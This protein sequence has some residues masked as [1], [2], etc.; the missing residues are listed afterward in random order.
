MRKVWRIWMWRIWSTSTACSASFQR[1]FF[2]AP[3]WTN[4]SGQRAPWGRVGQPSPDSWSVG[5]LQK[6]PWLC[7]GETL[8]WH[9][10][11]T[12]H[13][14]APQPCPELGRSQQVLP[15]GD[16]VLVFATWLFPPSVVSWLFGNDKSISPFLTVQFLPLQGRAASLR[17]RLGEPSL[18]HT[19]PKAEHLNPQKLVRVTEL[20]SPK[21]TS[22]SKTIPQH[23]LHSC[24]SH[25]ICS[26]GGKSHTGTN[27][28]RPTHQHHQA[29]SST[30]QEKM[31]VAETAL[32][33]TART[34]VGV[35]CWQG[36]SPPHSC[37]RQG[38]K[39]SVPWVGTGC[40]QPSARTWV[41]R[42][43]Q[44]G[45]VTLMHSVLLCGHRPLSVNKIGDDFLY[46]VGF[47]DATISIWED[48]KTQECKFIDT[49][50]RKAE[51]LSSLKLSASLAVQCWYKTTE[52]T[53]LA[54]PFPMSS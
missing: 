28:P 9:I 21:S 24:S 34:Q 20:A 35:F 45:P 52:D 1:E 22:L 40:D 25:K 47:L 46:P 27:P 19:L 10:T 18:N 13:P 33:P 3:S 4:L 8:E 23:P 42:L 37:P 36:K 17:P 14:G 54:M 15:A 26:G 51:K 7:P 39:Q 29:G 6:H 32:I 48:F 16:P 31:K 50:V 30:S 2:G 49:A 38:D 53:V 44:F 12:Y 5:V 43:E 11:F 41:W